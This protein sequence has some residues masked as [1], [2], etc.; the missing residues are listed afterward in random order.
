[1]LIFKSKFV[2]KEQSRRQSCN[3]HIYIILKSE[4]II[5]IFNPKQYKTRNIN[6]EGSTC[7]SLYKFE[8]LHII[9]D[10]GSFS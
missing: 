9:L 2:F 10:K 8:N 1:M 4:F 3:T 5:N 6:I 7:K